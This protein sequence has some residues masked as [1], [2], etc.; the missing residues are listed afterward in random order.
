MLTKREASV[1]NQTIARKSL[2]VLIQ[3]T[4]YYNSTNL[5]VYMEPESTI[6]ELIGKNSYRAC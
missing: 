2:L 4:A 1:S 6:M 3:P 5:L